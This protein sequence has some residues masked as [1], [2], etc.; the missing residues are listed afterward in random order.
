MRRLGEL[1]AE[2]LESAVRLKLAL[3]AARARLEDMEDEGKRRAAERDIAIL[4]QMLR[5]TREVAGLAAHYYEPGYW[6][7]KRYSL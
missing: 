6:R 7:D 4:E 3:R 5:D 1:A 2:Y